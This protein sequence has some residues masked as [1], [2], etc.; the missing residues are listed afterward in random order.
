MGVRN[1]YSVVEYAKTKK[2]ALKYFRNRHIKGAKVIKI[3][4]ARGGMKVE[5]IIQRK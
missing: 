3:S 1:L 2:T 4:P 5:F